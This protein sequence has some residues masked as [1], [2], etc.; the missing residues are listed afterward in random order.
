[1]YPAYFLDWSM[2]V[3]ML[4]SSTF[5]T[6]AGG[7]PWYGDGLPLKSTTAFSTT[8]VVFLLLFFAAAAAAA[9]VL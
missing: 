9:G 5:E 7:A 3:R 1:V 2:Q 8:A 6:F 4:P